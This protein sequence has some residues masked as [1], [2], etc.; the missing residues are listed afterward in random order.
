MM[1][2]PS[3]LNF[4][5]HSSLH[6]FKPRHHNC[7]HR[8]Q[9]GIHI[10]RRWRR[11]T[12]SFGNSQVHTVPSIRKNLCFTLSSCSFLN[13]FKKKKKKRAIASNKE[14]KSDITRLTVIRPLLSGNPRRTNNKI[15]NRSYWSPRICACIRLLYPRNPDGPYKGSAEPRGPPSQHNTPDDS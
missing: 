14:N 13:L 3:T 9:K 2:S 6:R 1:T 8:R 15:E 10:R 7:F 12:P 5:P 11:R 4:S